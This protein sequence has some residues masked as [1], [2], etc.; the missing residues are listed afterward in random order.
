MRFLFVNA[1]GD[2]M[3]KN[4]SCAIREFRRPVMMPGIGSDGAASEA[5][6]LEAVYINGANG[7]CNSGRAGRWVAH[8]HRSGATRGC[9]SAVDIP[10]IVDAD[11]GRAEN[12]REQFVSSA[13]GLP[14]VTLKIKN[15]RNAVGI[16]LERSCRC[17]RDGG[18]DQNSRGSGR[19]P[20]YDC[21]TDARG[22]ED[23]TRTI[24]RAQHY[25]EAG[26]DAIS[27]SAAERR[28]PRFRGE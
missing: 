4:E 5:G 15:F 27:R 14:V 2:S 10:A 24:D 1:Q 7:Q 25:L 23:F 3:K 12:W 9:G 28:I 13:R 18:K 6:W 20:F 22:V 26:A 11:T 16:S 21:R 19:I 8:T 17:R